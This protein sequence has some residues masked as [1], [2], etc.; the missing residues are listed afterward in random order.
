MSITRT[1]ILI[2]DDHAVVRAGLRAALAVNP[3]LVVVGEAVDGR[4]ACVQGAALKPDVV[5][6]DLVMPGLNGT[7]ATRQLLT[8]SPGSK[9]IALTAREDPVYVREALRA[10]ARGYVLKR[11]R[12]QHLLRAID[13]VVEG[14]MF[15]DAQLAP[16]PL[17]GISPETSDPEAELSLREIEV[18]TLA[19]MGHSNAEIAATLTIAI[20]T[21][22]THKTRLMAKLGFTSRAELVRYAV[23]RGWLM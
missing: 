7:D 22:E 11:T 23:Y 12:L 19:A 17:A 14:G 21:V 16:Q 8:L 6:M 9:V 4:D 15:L 13:V 20:K 10:G 3:A 18:G 5:I 2:V 1:R